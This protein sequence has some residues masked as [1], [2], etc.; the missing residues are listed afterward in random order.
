M[1]K[2][3][4]AIGFIVGFFTLTSIATPP[5]ICNTPKEKWM[6]ESDLRRVLLRQGYLIGTIKIVSGCYEFYGLDP[7][8]RRIQILIDP[9]TAKPVVDRDAASLPI[10]S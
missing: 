1:L 5:L 7:R 8:G 6:K 4:I 10:G 9:E 2:V 3:K